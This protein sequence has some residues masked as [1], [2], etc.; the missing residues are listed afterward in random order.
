M[1]WLFK[2]ISRGNIKS[3]YILFDWM[4]WLFKQI[5]KGNLKSSYCLLWLNELIVQININ[6]KYQILLLSDCSNELIVQININ[7]KSQILLL[8]VWLNEFIVQININWKYQILLHPIWLN[9][10]IV[11]I[12]TNMIPLSVKGGWDSKIPMRN[13]CTNNLNHLSETR[14]QKSEGKV[15]KKYSLR[16]EFCCFKISIVC[17]TLLSSSIARLSRVGLDCKKE[18]IRVWF[19]SSSCFRVYVSSARLLLW[20]QPHTLNMQNLKKK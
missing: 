13:D 3:S 20:I 4:S 6:W 16:N 10:L 15:E 19:G 9:E 1:S 17:A 18:N 8:P 12:N 11:Q 2:Q 7:W 14:R 5:S